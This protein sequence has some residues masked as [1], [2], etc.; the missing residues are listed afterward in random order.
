M[1]FATALLVRAGCLQPIIRPALCCLNTRIA[2]CALQYNNT[3]Q[4]NILRH[5]L[6]K[7]MVAIATSDQ[8]KADIAK[9]LNKLDREGEAYMK[10]TEKKCCRL[11]SGCI[12]FSP[13][14]SLWI[15]QSQVYCS[16]LRWHAG[17]VRN[18]GNIRCTAWRCQINTPFQLTVDDIK[19]RLRICKEKCDCFW[20]HRK[21]HQWQHL[22]Q[23][24]ERAQ[25]WE[26]E[27]AGRQI[28]AIVKREKDR[29]FWQRL[30][31]ALG[32]H[33]HGRSVRAVQV[34]DGAGGVIDYDTE[35]TVH[36]A[37]FNKVHRKW[38]NLAEEAPICQGR[39]RGEFGY[40]S[41]S[42]TAQTVLDGT[43]DFPPDMDEAT[44]ELFEEIAQIRTI[45]PSNSVTGVISRERWQQHW[46]K[47]KEDTSLSQ[48]GLQFGHY[49][50]GADCNYILQFHALC[51]SLALKKG[52]ALERWS[53]GLSVMLEKMFGVRL[54][55]KLRAILLMEADFNAMNKE[56]Y[57]VRMLDTARKYKLV[58]EEIF[59]EK[60]RM[61]DDGGLA[62]TLFY[63][64]MR[65]TRSPAAI[66]SV[67]ASNC[68]NWIAHAMALLIF[69]SFGVEDTAVAMMLETIKEMRT[70]T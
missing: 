31:F 40:V 30:N 70:G 13:E 3:L 43:Y 48:S 46:K 62:K 67:D 52:I 66:A 53:N 49:I 60:N 4:Q 35:E 6:L 21:R 36:Q 16:L 44:R 42:P 18:H 27:A 37:I 26:D 59:S 64:I 22:N 45:I 33:I 57:G 24:L 39:L 68:Y 50:A 47:V 28:L 38:Y 14:G 29:A 17:K 58:P 25:E 63:D 65:Q 61:A 34:E 23:C 55:S 41:M 69:Q 2:G 20:K 54:V 19:L 56:V 32:K 8:P 9:A 11:K 10:H 12:P 51:I 15:W 5:R 7:R 1:D